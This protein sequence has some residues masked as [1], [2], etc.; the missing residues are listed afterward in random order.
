MGMG[1]EGLADPKPRLPARTE[2]Q[3]ICCFKRGRMERS[4]RVLLLIW[5]ILDVFLTLSSACVSVDN[6]FSFSLFLLFSSR[7]RAESLY[8]Y[9]TTSDHSI[10][11][12][13][14]GRSRLFSLGISSES[15]NYSTLHDQVDKK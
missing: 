10:I 15:E 9:Y 6:L 8:A 7:Q 14:A 5:H 3:G 13:N 11:A 1:S 2:A 4:C 12:R